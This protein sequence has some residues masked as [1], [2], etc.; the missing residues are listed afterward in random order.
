MKVLLT[1]GS[2]QL[3]RELLAA[4]P[5]DVQIEAPA[6]EDLSITD[7]PAVLSATKLLRPAVV[8]NA[9]AYT[10]VDAAEA[11]PETA[12]EVNSAGART[13]AEAVASVG[14]RMIQVST[15]FVFDGNRN[16]PY[17]TTDEVNPLGVYGE[18]K[19]AGERAVLEVLDSDSLIVRTSW[20]YSTGG[21]SF[22]AKVLQRTAEGSDL[23]V[24]M[25]QVGSPTWA[26]NLA[27]AIWAW[28]ALPSAS[29][30]RHFC[31]AGIASR[32]DFAVAIREEASR[33]G[34]LHPDA[35]ASIIRP[36]LTGEFPARARRPAWSVLDARESWDELGLDPMHWRKSLVR[37]L[38]ELEGEPE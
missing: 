32:Y 8:I 33:L 26:R 16:L 5:A 3:G 29:G 12:W 6:K 30:V 27:Q 28:S 19:L 9:A 17:S 37:A 11:E 18:S 1:G 25:D 2:G 35:E 21:D 13:L 36:I 10:A 31:D 23:P 38:S 4:A 15:D 34:L 20:L 24:V 14:A 7:R 22:V